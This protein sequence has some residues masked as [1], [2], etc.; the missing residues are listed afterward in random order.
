[1]SEDRAKNIINLYAIA[2][3]DAVNFKNLYQDVADL[4]FPRENQITTVTTPGERRNVRIIDDTGVVAKDEMANGLSINLFPPGQKFYNIRM[5][6]RELNEIP[7][8]KR[9]LGIITEIS[10][11]KRNASNFRLEAD[12]TLKS[13]SAFGTGN[14][15]SSYKPGVGLNYKDYDVGQYVIQQN[16]LRRIDTMLLKFPLTATQAFEMF[17]DKVGETV[18][19]ALKDDKTATKKFDFIYVTRPR[20]KR[21]RTS[22]D[23]LNMPFEEICVSVRDLV[24]VKEDGFEEFPYMVPRWT[25]SSNEIWGRGQGVQVLPRVQSLQQMKHDYLECANKHNNPPLEV[26]DTFEDD[27]DVRPGARNDVQEIGTIRAIE[28][29]ALGNFVITKDALEA[30]QELVKKGFLNDIFVQFMN[31]KGDRRNE[32]ELRERLTEGLQRL[33]PPVGRLQEEWLKPMVERDIFLLARNGEFPEMPPEMRGKA[34]KIDFVGR[35]AMELQN[36]EAQGWLRWAGVGGELEAVFP[37]V[38]DNVKVDAGYRR[39]ATS[40][41]VSTEDINTVDEV[42]AIREARAERVAQE[43]QRELAAQVAQA[44]PGATKAPEPG[45]IAEQLIGV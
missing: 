40:F 44:Y 36:Q 10:H 14:L 42:D 20:R 17:G 31:L 19:E 37:G 11:E 5:S 28:R 24:V 34:F 6:D 13:I 12:E 30:E 21:T 26:V 29:A 27:V 39:L 4:I 32:L 23:P 15:F 45:S 38:K 8:V 33:G 35:L 18:L 22:I 3:S 16:S 7:E 25:K 1:M 9:M 41:G 43:Q 2:E